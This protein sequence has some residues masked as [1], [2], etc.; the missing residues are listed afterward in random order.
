MPLYQHSSKNFTWSRDSDVI[1]IIIATRERSEV[2]SIS[3]TENEK[4]T[5]RLF[6][7]A[8]NSI[9]ADARFINVH[10]DVR[11]SELHESSSSYNIDVIL[12]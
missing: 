2:S 6:L 1:Q 11:T 4:S 5:S 3:W 7:L 9:E 8:E 10:V 12:V